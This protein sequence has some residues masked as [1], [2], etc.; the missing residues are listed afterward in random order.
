[1]EFWSLFVRVDFIYIICTRIWFTL[2]FLYVFFFFYVKMHLTNNF[3]IYVWVRISVYF[4]SMLI[5]KINRDLE[6]MIN[7]FVVFFF[8]FS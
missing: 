7:K 3:L 4:Y 8:F 2:T 6:R 1:M 5:Y